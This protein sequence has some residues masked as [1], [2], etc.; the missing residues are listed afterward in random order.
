MRALRRT[1]TW[2]LGLVGSFALASLMAFAAVWAGLSVVVSRQ[3]VSAGEH[4]AQFHAEFV[5]NSI[6]RYEL[7]SRNLAGPIRGSSYQSLNR[8]VRT[9]ILQPPVVRVKIW[10]PDGMVL[11]SDE[12]RLVGMRFD[13]DPDQRAA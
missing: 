2:R 7:T 10:S 4:G 12:P 13:G 6:L 11:Y 3:V 9:R 1:L 8:F 5:T